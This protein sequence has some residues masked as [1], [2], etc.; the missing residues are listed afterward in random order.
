MHLMILPENRELVRSGSNT[1]SGEPT[2]LFASFCFDHIFGEVVRIAK[3]PNVCLMTLRAL[4]E[5]MRRQSYSP[6]STHSY[7]HA[8][9]RHDLQWE[10]KRSIGS[11]WIP[12]D[13]IGTLVNNFHLSCVAVHE[14]SVWLLSGCKDCSGERLT[15]FKRRY[16]KKCRTGHVGI[17]FHTILRQQFWHEVMKSVKMIL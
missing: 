17:P 3:I 10:P 13:S 15:R 1:I 2:L 12:L 8:E 7:G 5:D 4:V 14:Y 16:S 9:I 6:A 11:H